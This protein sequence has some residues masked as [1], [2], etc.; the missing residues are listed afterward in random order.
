M[1]GYAFYRFAV[2]RA[3]V[4]FCPIAGL[5]CSQAKSEALSFRPAPAKPTA[6]GT[7]KLRRESAAFV[8]IAAVGDDSAPA[9]VR[10]PWLLVYG[11]AEV[12][13]PRTAR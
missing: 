10:S 3:F 9:L 2:A 13:L 11:S 12:A 4:V 1:P 5:G 7:V 6:P 8:E